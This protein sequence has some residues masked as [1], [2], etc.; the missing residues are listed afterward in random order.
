MLQNN[1]AR[2]GLIHLAENRDTT[3]SNHIHCR[4]WDKI[5][6]HLLNFN[7]WSL[8]MDKLFRPTLHLACDCDCLSMPGFKLIH[9]SKMTITSHPSLYILVL[10]IATEM[11]ATPPMP[12]YSDGIMSTMG[13]QITSLTIVYSSV[14]LC[15]DQRKHQSS[16]SLV[17]VRGIHRWPVNSPHKGPVTRIMFP[18]D[19]VIVTTV[20]LPGLYLSWHV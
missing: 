19:D 15:V 4:V 13:S 8:G 18:F 1:A 5:S 3:T 6:Y 20:T 14:Y 16:A 12:H 11:T 9:I 7:C 17:F 2:Q 10:H